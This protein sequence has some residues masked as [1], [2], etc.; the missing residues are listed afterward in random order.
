MPV[1]VVTSLFASQLILRWDASWP[2][3]LTRAS[4]MLAA[5]LLFLLFISG[6]GLVTGYTFR[7]LEPVPAWSTHRAI[8]IA[9]SISAVTHVLSLLFD[10][11]VG[12]NFL[13]LFVPFLSKYTPVTLFGRHMGSLWVALG[14]FSV[15]GVVAI[16]LTSLFWM[17]KKPGGWRI[18][19]YLAYLVIIMTFFHAFTLGTDIKYGTGRVIWIIGGLC[20]LAAIFNRIRLLRVKRI[21]KRAAA[22]GHQEA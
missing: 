15:Y 6:V 22:A 16:M 2:W 13:Q 9:F 17:N 14:I 12:F 11:Y 5:A 1:T 21:R 20:V 8:S 3:Y 7:Y 18:T 4:G 19:H 10:K